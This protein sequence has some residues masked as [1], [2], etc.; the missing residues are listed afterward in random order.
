[1]P[2]NKGFAEKQ[3]VIMKNHAREIFK[4]PAIFRLFLLVFL[5]TTLSGC[6]RFSDVQ[7]ESLPTYPGLV[8]NMSRA[9]CMD[10]CPIYEIIIRGDGS[11]TYHGYK[12]VTIIE[13]RE[14]TITQDE[15][16]KLVKE[17]EA[18]NFLEIDSPDIRQNDCPITVVSFSLDGKSNEYYDYYVCN[19]NPFPYDKKVFEIAKMIDD[20]TNSEQWLGVEAVKY[21]EKLAP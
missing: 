18:I 16:R 6:N 5:A 8:I 14:T 21:L 10:P 4:I 20:I 7:N 9:P 2:P 1:M 11:V 12:Y 19:S 17:F 3:G 13:T 15:I